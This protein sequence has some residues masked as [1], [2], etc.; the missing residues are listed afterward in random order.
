METKATTGPG[1]GI[2]GFR[3]QSLSSEWFG[4]PKT[5]LFVYLHPQCPITLHHQTH[6]LRYPRFICISRWATSWS[7]EN[8]STP[9]IHKA[10]RNR[11]E[12]CRSKRLALMDPWGRQGWVEAAFASFPGMAWTGPFC[13]APG[14]RTS[15]SRGHPQNPKPLNPKP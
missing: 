10:A 5:L 2:C 11:M 3:A 12:V 15:D 8:L 6:V 9:V 7:T 14:L 13:E 1:T 4:V